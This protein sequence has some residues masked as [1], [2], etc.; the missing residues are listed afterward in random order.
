LSAEHRDNPA[1]GC[2]LAALLP[3]P[4]RQPSE[5]RSLFADRLLDVSRQVSAALPPATRDRE[6]VAI[7]LQATLIGTPQLARAVQGAVLSDRI[8]AVGADAARALVRSSKDQESPMKAFI[9]DRYKGKLRFGDMLDPELRDHDVLVQIYAAGVNPLDSKIR[10]GEFKL[11]LPYR[12]PLIL[13]N[14]LAGDAVR[15]GSKVRGSNQ[16]TRSMRGR[17][18]T[19]SGPLRNSSP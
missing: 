17:T 16:V 4:A 8:L 9:I 6:T 19:G 2:T 14:E 12:F 18:R 1:K 10:D 11:I 5:T 15:V 7:V 13:G 3:E